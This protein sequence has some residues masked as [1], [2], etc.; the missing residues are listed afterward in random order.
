[1]G[2]T[3]YWHQKRSFTDNEW[4]AVVSEYDYLKECGR[5]EPWANNP[6]QI[7]FNAKGDGCETFVLHK[8][9]EDNFSDSHHWR[10]ERFDKEGYHF[11]FCKTRMHSYDIDVWHLLTVCHIVA[12][13]VIIDISRDR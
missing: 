11:D 4:L 1:M 3:N 10:K 5:I 7:S 13:D 8:N 9:I 12:P 6:C 2:Y